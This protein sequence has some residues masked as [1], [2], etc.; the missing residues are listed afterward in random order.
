[1]SE[2]PDTRRSAALGGYCVMRFMR[3]IQGGVEDIEGMVAQGQYG[4][5]ASM[6]RSVALLCLSIRSLAHG[7]PI[8]LD[9]ESVSFDVFACVPADESAAALTL[10]REALDIDRDSAAAWLQRF[11][12]FVAETERLLGYDGPLP[13]L[14]SPE[15]AFAMIRVA[16]RWSPV[17]AQLGLPP[18]LPERWAVPAAADGA[19]RA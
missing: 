15:G 2:V 3:R 14:R 1:M 19:K 10:A 12:A 5:A 8:D 18:L 17:L 16:R 7:A 4:A 13:L 11:I 9:E 6:A